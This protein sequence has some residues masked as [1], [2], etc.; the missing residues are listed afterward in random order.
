M[1]PDPQSD[2][3]PSEKTFRRLLGYAGVYRG[4][5]ALGVLF[6]IV[7]GGS[8]VGMFG[9][10]R[11]VLGETF[12]FESEGM[13]HTALL[14]VGMMVWA[15]LRG[16]GR[17]ASS[18]LLQWVGQRVILDL[19][20]QLFRHLEELSL[21]D[22]THGRVGEFISRISSDT[23][24][25]QAAVSTV[26]TDLIRQP[27]VLLASVGY[28]LHLNWRLALGSVV[29]IPVC[30]GPM[31]FLGKRVRR[32]SRE[33]QERMGDLMSVMEEVFS[34]IRVVKAFGAEAREADRFRGECR[35]F[36]SKI[37][38]VVRNREANE[39]II[40][41][42][43]AIGGLAT[44]LYARHIQMPWNEFIIFVVAAF[45]VYD[46]IKRLSRIHLTIQ[47]SAGAADRVFELLDTPPIVTDAPDA[48]ELK[49][50]IRELQFDA[51]RFCYD[52]NPVI[53][54]IDLRIASGK[55]VALVGSSGAGKTTL[56]NL[57]MRFYDVNGGAVRANGID[58]RELTVAS[59]RA[60][61]GLVTQETFLFNDTVANNIAYGLP[62]A[63]REAVVEA[64]RRA[65]AHDFI[66]ALEGG[67][68]YDTPIGERGSRLSGG[69]RQRL[70]I[71]RAILC[72]PP[73]LLLDEATSALDTESERQVQAALDEL[74]RD[75][76]VVAIAHRLSTI[77]KCDQIVVLGE[78]HILEQGSHAELLAQDGAYT[79]LYRMQFSE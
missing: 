46:P 67:A 74:M 7:L 78:G 30:A 27:I 76:T 63:S 6:S 51:V 10:M 56:V 38:R 31:I 65:H 57:L 24:M 1:K 20:A 54:G 75:R 59:L 17:F 5:L 48:Q 35:A 79:R 9:A 13:Q 33:G 32:A 25:L 69:Q 21:K 19:R 45:S 8:M 14:A 39:P 40:T 47:Q 18:Y 26:L 2:S 12:D 49:E 52:S 62:G 61:M 53:D 41:A 29:L 73:V 50:Q 11:E 23:Q 34:G 15:L 36:F 4:R 72:D 77:V 66:E 58:I 28:L 70:A 71:A 43:A 16:L 64:A 55:S 60:Q 37:M 68:G 3:V 22:F 44:L 42:V